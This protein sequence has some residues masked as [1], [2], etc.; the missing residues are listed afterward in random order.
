MLEDG[1]W[2]SV[3]LSKGP[4]EMVVITQWLIEVQHL[5]RSWNVLMYLYCYPN[6]VLISPIV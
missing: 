1:Q 6:Q 2:V 3:I 5:I 4:Y